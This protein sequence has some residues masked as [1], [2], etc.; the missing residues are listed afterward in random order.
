MHHSCI[1]PINFN[2][3]SISISQERLT[4]TVVCGQADEELEMQY[5]EEL[6]ALHDAVTTARFCSLLVCYTIKYAVIE[7]A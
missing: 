1:H 2:L 5:Q 3:L 7:T 6:Q 4:G